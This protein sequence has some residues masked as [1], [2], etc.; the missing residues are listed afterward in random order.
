MQNS[1]EFDKIYFLHLSNQETIAYRK[2]THPLSKY[3]LVFLHSQG[4]SSNVFEDLFN[5]LEKYSEFDLYALDMRGFGESTLNNSVKNFKDLSEDI[6][7]F[8]ELM[9]LKNITLVGFSTG[10][11]VALD[12]ASTY[13]G[14]LNSLILL[15]SQS[16]RGLQQYLD[17]VSSDGTIL[18][19]CL[20]NFE[21]LKQGH[22]G[23]INECIQKKDIEF[24]EDYYKKFFFNVGKPYPI[25]KMMKILEGTFQQ[26]HFLEIMWL[27]HNF[28]ITNEDNGVNKGTGEISKIKIPTLIIHGDQDIIV[29]IKQAEYNF[30]VLGEKIARIEILP[31]CGHVPFYTE[32]EKT[33]L[34]I[35]KFII[36]EDSIL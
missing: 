25:Q 10:G 32:D 7:L 16:A 29:P 8:I 27:L 1:K 24:C 11:A 33:A 31:N 18:Q 17:Y 36:G 6:Y 2:I 23:H 26:K 5:L 3:T 13:P 22:W 14:S 4:N 15:A 30:K 20:T 28:N 9:N 21:E 35:K 19:K 12:F 34:L